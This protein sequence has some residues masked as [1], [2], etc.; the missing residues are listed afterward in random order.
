M[1][2]TTSFK[3]DIKINVKHTGSV[4]LSGLR[5]IISSYDERNANYCDYLKIA[6]I[7]HKLTVG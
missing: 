1:T 2:K 3:L 6:R 5:L 4:D 7:K